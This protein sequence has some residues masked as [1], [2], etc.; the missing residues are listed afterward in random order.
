MWIHNFLRVL[1]NKQEEFHSHSLWQVQPLFRELL[2]AAL[3]LLTTCCCSGDVGCPNCI[4]VSLQKPLPILHL[5]FAEMMFLKVPH[6]AESVL[7]GIQWSFRQNC[8]HYDYWGSYH[9]TIARWKV[10]RFRTGLHSSVFSILGVVW[11]LNLREHFVPFFSLFLSLFM[12]NRHL[13]IHDSESWPR[14]LINSTKKN[15][16]FRKFYFYD[17]FLIWLL[18]YFIFNSLYAV[19]KLSR[20]FLSSGFCMVGPWSGFLNVGSTE[21]YS[22][23]V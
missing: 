19:F 16:W 2:S 22:G 9:S 14:G 20:C 5:S 12:W 3:E 1:L 7:W 10:F 15:T 23:P 11:I 17:L 6:I 21:T 8:C 13:V 18:L 4:Q